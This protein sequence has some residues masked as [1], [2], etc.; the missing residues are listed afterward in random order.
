MGRFD[1]R[2]AIVTGAASGVGRATARRLCA[3]GAEV[4]GVD[5]DDAGLDE[6]AA[7]TGGAFVAGV[8]DVSDRASCHA[9]VA[10]A[11]EAFGRLDVVANV[12]GVAR[13][14]HMTDVDEDEWRLIMGVNLDGVFWLT[15]A[16]IP[17]LLETGGNV[18]NVA[19]S[20]GLMGQAYMVPYCA[21]KAGVVN[22]TRAMAM[23]LV[24]TSVR[25]NA[26]APG[27]MATA[28][29]ERFEVPEGVDLALMAP[30]AGFRGLAEPESCASAICWL[31]SDEA[32]RCHGTILSIDGGVTAG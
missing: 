30:Y 12:A 3:E 8:H 16:A 29:T 31:A 19:S 10:A 1:G 27:G 14:H 9:A 5:I 32:A 7:A 28:L 13:A 26:V 22:L 6:L 15:Q 25:V 17:H 2:A 20:S 23:E 4:Y 21:A 24:K 18:V 11:V